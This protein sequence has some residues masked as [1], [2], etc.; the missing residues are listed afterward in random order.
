M[1]TGIG[2]PVPDQNGI[3]IIDHYSENGE[4]TEKLFQR[5]LSKQILSVINRVE[6]ARVM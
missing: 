5:A 6:K 1:E 4:D 3:V 2:N